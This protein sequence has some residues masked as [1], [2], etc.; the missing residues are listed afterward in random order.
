MPETESHIGREPVPRCMHLWEKKLEI[1]D[2]VTR[3]TCR[4]LWLTTVNNKNLSRRT[5]R[6]LA[7]EA[8]SQLQGSH[9]E[10]AA[11]SWK[12]PQAMDIKES[13]LQTVNDGRP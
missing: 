12:R 13:R 5:R 11:R 6:D 8:L 9:S 1:Q 10:V 7:M 2:V 3:A 4:R